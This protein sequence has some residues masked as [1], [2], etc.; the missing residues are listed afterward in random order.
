MVALSGFNGDL[1]A[2]CTPQSWR[3]VRVGHHINLYLSLS[4]SVSVSLVLSPLL[5]LS[6]PLSQPTSQFF[7][8][9]YPLLSLSIATSISI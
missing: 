2:V 7:I 4:L 1:N 9:Q 5:S 6:P 8:C 3:Q